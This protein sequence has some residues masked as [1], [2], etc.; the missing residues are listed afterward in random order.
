MNSGTSAV[1][2]E[3]RTVDRDRV[4]RF[5]SIVFFGVLPVLVVC[6][7]FAASIADS[8]YAIDFVQ[9]YRGGEHVLAGQHLYPAR[10]APLTA[11]SHPSPYVYPPLSALLAAP[12]TALP[13]E[14][15]RVILMG[16]LVL[17]VLL[18]LR[19]LEVHD[20]R[21]YG[22]VLLWPPVISAVQT[23]NPTLWLALATA[24]AWR[25]RDR[26]VLAPAAIGA[27]FAVKFV[28]WPLLVWFAA[29][30]RIVSALLALFVGGMLLLVS[31][32]VIG[33]EGFTGY[34]DLLDRL[35]RT[36]GQDSYSVKNLALD[37]GV[38]SGAA[39]LM[40]LCVGLGLLVACVALARSGDDALGSSSVSSPVSHFRRS[41][42]C[43][44]SRSSSSWSQLPA[45]DSASCGSFLSRCTSRR[46][47]G[48]RRRP[49]SRSRS[50]LPR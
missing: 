25:Y 39:K 2:R 46:G 6:L 1:G 48:T 28:L 4:V 24:L 26:S 13:I 10:D 7:V 27:T 23:A 15:D 18:I 44:T 33:F 14:V 49:R 20:W 43:T 42:G 16:V 17:V 29:T 5:A 22:L 40:W 8:T 32:S 36:V 21:C 37:Y 38:S 9:F 50:R 12:F 34:P 31:W 35:D 11:W 3:R 45:P 19:V 41:C 47:R 30:K